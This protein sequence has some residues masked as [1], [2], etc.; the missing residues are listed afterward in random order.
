ME[1]CCVLCIQNCCHYY[2]NN[3]L[4]VG[5][6]ISIKSLLCVLSIHVCLVHLGSM[7]KEILS[8][9]A[10]HPSILRE[11]EISY[12]HFTLCMFNYVYCY[13]HHQKEDVVSFVYIY[14]LY[15]ICYTMALYLVIILM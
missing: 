8:F 1:N 14:T 7:S 11:F 13:G 10:Y 15:I 3:I 2:L 9:K 12:L 6:A 4:V 5:Y